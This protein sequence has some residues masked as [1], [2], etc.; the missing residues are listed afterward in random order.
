MCH[1]PCP[2]TTLFRSQGTHDDGSGIAVLV[3]NISE[4]GLLLESDAAIAVGDRIEIDL[5]H[6]GESP[7]TVVW[8]SDRLVGCRFDTAI[9]PATL[10]AAQLSTA[11]HTSEL[12]S[13]MRISYTVF[14]FTK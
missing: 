13:L 4:S 6:A 11:E 14:R 7:A 5:P 9:S 3:H 8:V 2:C 1:K 10:S 12:Q